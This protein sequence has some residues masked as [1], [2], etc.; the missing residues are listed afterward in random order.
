M[1]FSLG[2]VGEGSMLFSLGQVEEGS[3]LF[4]LGQVLGL[5]CARGALCNPVESIR[6]AYSSPWEASCGRAEYP[7]SSDCFAPVRT[8][9]NPAESI[10][11]AYSLPW[12]ASCGRCR[13]ILEEWNLFSR[14]CPMGG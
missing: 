7:G 3:M 13:V 9:C 2:Q 10:R 8:L 6:K 5:L 12:E 14:W 11:K 1:L 4:S